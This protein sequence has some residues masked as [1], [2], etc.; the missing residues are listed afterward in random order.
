MINFIDH[1]F[2]EK[3]IFKEFFAEER[4]EGNFTFLAKELHSNVNLQIIK[5]RFSKTRGLRMLER[6]NFVVP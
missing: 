2:L 1:V 3:Y 5:I 4:E 6:R